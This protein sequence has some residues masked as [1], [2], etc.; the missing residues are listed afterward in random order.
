MIIRSQ[1]KKELHNLDGIKMIRITTNTQDYFIEV[2][3]QHDIGIYSS[4]EKAIKVMNMIQ[5]AYV[6]KC[7]FIQLPKDC[8]V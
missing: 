7:L 8:E 5:D 4:E 6:Q 3:S 2:N 1:N